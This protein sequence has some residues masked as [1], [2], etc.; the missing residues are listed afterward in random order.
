MSARSFTQTG[1]PGAETKTRTHRLR[2]DLGQT[3]LPGQ[4]SMQKC[5]QE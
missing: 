2:G 5:R 4:R 1:D 3:F